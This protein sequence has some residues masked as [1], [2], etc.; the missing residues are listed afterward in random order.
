MIYDAAVVW[1]VDRLTT[2]EDVRDSIHLFF[3]QRVTALLHHV[4][5]GVLDVAKRRGYNKRSPVSDVTFSTERDAA[6]MGGA[7]TAELLS[8]QLDRV[9][10]SPQFRNSRRCQSLLRFVVESALEG[11]ADR[12]KERVIGSAVFGRDADY[13]TNQDAVV[14][15]AAAE[16][17]KR[18]AQ[19]Y[20][21]SS[22]EGEIRIEMPS[23]SYV[24][25]FH[26]LAASTP[27]APVAVHQSRGSYKITAMI[28]AVI[29]AAA[30]AGLLLQYWGQAAPAATELDEFWAPTLNAPNAVQLCVGQSR[31]RYLPTRLSAEDEAKGEVNVPVS[32]LV[33]MLDKFLWYGDSVCM[34]RITGYLAA[35]NKEVRIRGALTTP[36]SEIRGNAVVLIGAFNNEWTARLTDGLRFSLV[37]GSTPE[38]RGV[39]DREKG[40]SLLWSV[41][42]PRG[43]WSGT[44]YALVTRV[45]DATTEEAVVAAGGIEHSGTMAAGDF[46]STPGYFR[47]ALRNAPPDWA[48]KNVQIVLQT[49]VVDGTP[50]PPRVLAAHFW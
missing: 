23:G 39:R 28:L 13:D 26:L 4:L 45:F 42:K 19:Y 2:V 46:L 16:V 9:L 8:Q 18:L 37:N 35:H 15:N 33:P 17:R 21:E 14:R 25:E 3:F 20:L 22:Q 41:R 27:A 5:E 11:N 10:C 43:T 50:G 47:D 24:P 7:V 12:L 48:K 30:C 1:G 38:I 32:E 36:Y 6:A 49:E 31:L 29:T 40:S 44:D 34:A